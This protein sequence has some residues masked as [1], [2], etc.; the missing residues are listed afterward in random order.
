MADKGTIPQATID[1]YLAGDNRHQRM[2]GE[3]FA[4]FADIQDRFAKHQMLGTMGFLMYELHGA[5]FLTDQEYAFEK[6]SLD[7]LMEELR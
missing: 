6:G 2:L 4:C 5:K 7:V 3:L 1:R